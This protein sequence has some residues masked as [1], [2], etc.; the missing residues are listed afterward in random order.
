[1]KISLEMSQP[2]NYSGLPVDNFDVKV[3]GC[4]WGDDS[5]STAAAVGIIRR[6]NKQRLL[7]L[8]ELA[9]ALVPSSNNLADSDFEL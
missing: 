6:A 4:T 2:S 3:Q 8:L 5:T 7:T 9:D 1:M